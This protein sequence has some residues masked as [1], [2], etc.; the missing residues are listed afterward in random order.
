MHT[1]LLAA[2]PAPHHAAEGLHTCSDDLTS[3]SLAPMETCDILVDRAPAVAVGGGGLTQHPVRIE[4]SRL[5]GPHTAVRA[6][7]C[8]LLHR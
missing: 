8:R 2:S 6:G 3:R 1:A 4:T 7:L 5:G